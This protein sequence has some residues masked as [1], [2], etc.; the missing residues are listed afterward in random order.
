MKQKN[1][2]QYIK[3]IIESIDKENESNVNIKFPDTIPSSLLVEAD[4]NPFIKGYVYPYDKNRIRC[5]IYYNDILVGFMTPRESSRGWRIGAIYVKKEYSG[6]SI[7][8]IAIKKFLQDKKAAPVLIDTNNV[9]SQ[10]AFEKA[11]FSMDQAIY[12]WDDGS[13][14]YNIWFPNQSPHTI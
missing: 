8:S 5:G 1:L 13:G 12:D 6:K 7:S 11:G 4:Q 9:T 2:E 10:K 3:L 14:Q